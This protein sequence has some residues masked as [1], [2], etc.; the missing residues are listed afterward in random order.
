MNLC[1]ALSKGLSVV[2]S[3]SFNGI[4]T[5]TT[6]N[7][8]N[9]HKNINYYFYHHHNKTLI[10]YLLFILQREATQRD[11]DRERRLRADSES[12]T[13]QALQ[14]AARCRS[15][16]KLLTSEF[17]R[18]VPQAPKHPVYAFIVVR[19]LLECNSLCRRQE[20]YME[21]PLAHRKL[22]CNS[23]SA[24]KLHRNRVVSMCMSMSMG[25]DIAY[26]L[27]LIIA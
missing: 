25:V 22:S 3:V 2:V 4:I 19:R 23:Q 17:S 9:P 20:M 10:F 15:R 24:P 13:K 5:T 6:L 16:L 18:L 27:L 11:A 26:L 12:K 14:E 1:D 8:K 21:I 7:W